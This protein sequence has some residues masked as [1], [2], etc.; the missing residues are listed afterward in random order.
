MNSEKNIDT[1]YDDKFDIIK[2]KDTRNITCP[3]NVVQY[4]FVDSLSISMLEW[5]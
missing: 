1:K 3:H 4:I 5:K 2:A